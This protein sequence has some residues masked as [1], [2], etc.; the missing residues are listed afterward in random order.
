M[1]RLLWLGFILVTV[2]VLVPVQALA[3]GPDEALEA[4]ARELERK[5]LCP[6]CPQQTLDR[7][8]T[9]LSRQMK[10]LIRKKLAEG[11]TPEQ[12]LAYFVDRYGEKVLASPP[13][14]G[15]GFL[16]WFLPILPI[17]VAAVA[18]YLRLRR[19]AS[20]ASPATSKPLEKRYLE[21]LEKELRE[22]KD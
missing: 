12:I 18:L 19:L 5:L 2:V 17:S 10:A 7:S 16:L 1:N 20:S 14:R 3:Q 4:Q 9:E 13:R 8:E 6:I 15:W 11:E 22:R 21:R